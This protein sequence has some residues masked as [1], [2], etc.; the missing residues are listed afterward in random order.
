MFSTAVEN[1]SVKIVY[2]LTDRVRAELVIYE[3]SVET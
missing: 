2:V 3:I 1:I